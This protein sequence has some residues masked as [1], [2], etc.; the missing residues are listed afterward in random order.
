MLFHKY[1]R[2][3]SQPKF[4]F[5]KWRHRNIRWKRTPFYFLH[6]DA[7]EAIDKM[8]RIINCEYGPSNNPRV[9]TEKQNVVQLTS[10]EP[11]SISRSTTEDSGAESVYARYSLLL[12]LFLYLYIA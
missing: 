10:A 5:F 9:T 7:S 12:L 2:V 8:Q 11:L 6:H 1:V 4:I 3:A